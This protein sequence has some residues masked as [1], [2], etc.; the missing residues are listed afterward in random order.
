M[1]NIVERLERLENRTRRIEGQLW[2]WRITAL[3][4]GLVAVTLGYTLPGNAQ[5]LI[6]PGSVATAPFTIKA[7]DGTTLMT[8]A[9]FDDGTRKSKD[10][11]L[12]YYRNGQPA[13][14]FRTTGMTYRDAADPKDNFLNVFETWLYRYPDK[15]PAVAYLTSS[16]ALTRSGGSLV[17][18]NDQGPVSATP[19]FAL[20][21]SAQQGIGGRISLFN[22]DGKEAK[23]IDPK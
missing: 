16:T 17:L 22:P 1:D 23:V 5:Q 18:F 12:T 15:G 8:I 13:A 2:R 21:L 4:L 20:R 10:T 6:D 3:A 7:K 19:P 14:L 9:D 11:L